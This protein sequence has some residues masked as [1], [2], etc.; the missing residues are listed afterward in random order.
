MNRCGT[1]YPLFSHL[2][3]SLRC[4]YVCSQARSS[5]RKMQSGF[6]QVA[7]S[8]KRVFQSFSLD[9]KLEMLVICHQIRLRDDDSFSYWLEKKAQYIF[10]S[11]M[12]AWFFRVKRCTVGMRNGMAQIGLETNSSGK[13][14][15][16]RKKLHC[17]NESVGSN[18]M[19][20]SNDFLTFV[21][22]QVVLLNICVRQ[23]W[24]AVMK[25]RLQMTPQ[26]RRKKKLVQQV[27]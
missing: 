5:Q 23:R 24:K 18:N 6:T 11:R 13:F 17:Y 26:L 7:Y 9:C 20:L 19:V 27:K 15:K 1:Y 25:S 3:A 10:C 4:L 8:M 21:V 12:W 22:M 16:K 2:D 14:D